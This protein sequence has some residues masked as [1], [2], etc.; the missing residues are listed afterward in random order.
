M[1][2]GTGCTI[3]NTAGLARPK[4][5]VKLE[6]YGDS[7]RFFAYR[8]FKITRGPILGIRPNKQEQRVGRFGAT[9][10]RYAI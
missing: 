10:H 8:V 7:V 2:S 3:Q 4:L 9:H 5:V 1:R 6:Q